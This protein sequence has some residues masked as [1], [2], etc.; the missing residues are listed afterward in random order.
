MRPKILVCD[1]D[2]LL[3]RSLRELFAA[4]ELD[5][6]SVKTAAEALLALRQQLRAT[7]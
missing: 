1:D 3:G 2:A 6:E 7:S 4:H 5:C